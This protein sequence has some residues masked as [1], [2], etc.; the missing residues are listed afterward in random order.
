MYRGPGFLAVEWFCSYPTPS[1][2]SRQQVVSLSQTSCVVSISQT[3]C[4]SLFELTD[5]WR[6]WGRSQIIRQQESLVPYNSFNTLWAY[7]SIRPLGRKLNMNR[8]L[9]PVYREMPSL[10]AQLF[11]IEPS[12]YALTFVRNMHCSEWFFSGEYWSTRNVIWNYHVVNFYVIILC[13]VRRHV[14]QH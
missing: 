8:F 4:E 6:G 10:R 9:V 14:R 11:L 12:W 1:P 3:S 7:T 5:G 2:L 13:D